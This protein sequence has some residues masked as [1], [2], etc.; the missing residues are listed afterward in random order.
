MNS[1]NKN[2]LLIM[3]FLHYFITEKNYN[4]VIVHGIENEIWL[5]NMDNDIKIVRIVTGYIHNKE[6][7][8]FDSFKVE[9]L[10]K[11]IKLKTF[12]F[13]MKTLSLYLDLN[14]DVDI[15][16]TKKDY[17]VRVKNERSIK[18]SE[19]IKSFF[20]D[21]PSKL[22]FTEQG[23]LLYQKINTDI[24][25]K[26]IKESKKINDLFKFNKPIITYSLI[27]IM[28]I[29][30]LLMYFVSKGSIS[31]VT[32]YKFGALIKGG[33]VL[34]IITSIFLHAGLLHFIMNMWAL[35]L[36]GSQV[37]T[38]YGHIKTLIIFI[39]SGVIGNLISLLFME[40][41]TIS[42]GAS[43]A[44]FGLMGAILYFALNQ[45]TYMGEALKKEIL[46]VI[47]IN[48]LLGFM[49]SGINVYAHIGG[50]VGGVLISNAVGIKY[51]TSRSEKV[52]G[53]ISS[54]LLTLFLIFLVYFK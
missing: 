14:D 28:S 9:K 6:Q 19:V 10:T 2:D 39:Y 38:F 30:M 35:K 17:K 4:P 23:A 54:I 49:I 16:N 48:I 8:E 18:N 13:N 47:I 20:E 34:R 3:K 46:P 5:E 11:Q 24:M 1:N 45:R 25:N 31:L 15:V 26:N 50:I 21:M 52:N 22:K 51:K 41:N 27:V 42:V 37:E 36:L 32:L 44:I 33:S 29:I 7:L 40:E 43:G 53:A 12:T